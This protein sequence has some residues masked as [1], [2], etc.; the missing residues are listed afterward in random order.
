M[1]RRRGSTNLPN[2]VGREDTSKEEARFIPAVHST[3][4]EIAVGGAQDVIV[5]VIKRP[6]GG[7]GVGLAGPIKDRT[8]AAR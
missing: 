7:G 4:A 1:P 2:G 6:A 3:A 5:V 8:R